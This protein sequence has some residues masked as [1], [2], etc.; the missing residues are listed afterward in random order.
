MYTVSFNDTGS[1][2]CG[3]SFELVGKY[4]SLYNRWMLIVICETH[5][6]EPTLY[7]EGH[8]YARKLS[9]NESQLVN[10]LTQTNVKPCDI[11][12]TIKKTK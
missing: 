8:S 3:C 6:H 5:N 11:L 2:I 7:L 10:D 4:L 9:E 12:S 1:K